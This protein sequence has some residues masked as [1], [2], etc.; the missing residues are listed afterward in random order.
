MTSHKSPRPMHPIWRWFEWFFLMFFVSVVVAAFVS[1][2]AWTLSADWMEFLTLLSLGVTSFAVYLAVRIFRNQAVQARADSAARDDI[3]SRIDES[4]SQAAS[5]ADAAAI[6]IAEIKPHVIK[7]QKEKA[8][9][10]FSSE[11][12]EEALAAYEAAPKGPRLVLW[13]DDNADWIQLERE[14]FESAGASTVWV[15]NTARALEVLEGNSFGLVIS[16]MGRAEGDRE[17]YVLLDSMRRRG[18]DT[19]FIV[20]SSSRHPEHIAEIIE[21][22]GQGGTNDPTELFQLVMQESV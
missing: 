6:D 21:H 11:R 1:P 16:D 14:M 12:I 8:Q 15:P 18:D 20:Y 19:P 22:G 2:G 17:G 13:V 7:A 4:A 3:L 10:S 9:D 5:S